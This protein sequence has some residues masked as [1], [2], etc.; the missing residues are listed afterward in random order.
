[1]LKSEDCMIEK[2]NREKRTFFELTACQN[3]EVCLL[4]YE[5][6]INVIDKS[7]F[8][9]NN[10]PYKVNSKKNIMESFLF[11]LD[12][13]DIVLDKKVREKYQD[14]YGTIKITSNDELQDKKTNEKDAVIAW[15]DY[16]Q[17]VK[18]KF[19]VDSKQ[20]SYNFIKRYCF[21]STPNF[22]FTFCS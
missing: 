17:K 4:D 13:L 11:C 5:T 12:N 14:Y 19:G 9:K 22:S 7:T 20:I 15:Q 2:E 10:T 6:I 3:I 1:M 8:G 21:E 18:E 16:E